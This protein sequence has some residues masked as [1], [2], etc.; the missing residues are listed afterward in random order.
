MNTCVEF[1]S[2]DMPWTMPEKNCIIGALTEVKTE[3]Q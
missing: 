1:I 2:T 3:E